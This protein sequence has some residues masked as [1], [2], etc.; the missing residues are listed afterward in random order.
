MIIWVFSITWD[1]NNF[2]IVNIKT[3]DYHKP[4]ARV[5]LVILDFSIVKA[6]FSA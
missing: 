5:A 3:A 1:C 2:I 6:K 4:R